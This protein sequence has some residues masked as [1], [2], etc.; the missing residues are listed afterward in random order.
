MIMN[1]QNKSREDLFN[2]LQEVRQELDRLKTRFD[3]TIS[4]SE[5]NFGK[6]VISMLETLSIING[7]GD[8]IFVN[9]HAAENLS[10]GQPEDVIGRNIGDFVPPEQARELIETYRSVLATKQHVREER[11]ITL[12][13]RER[14]FSNKL[15]FI[16]WGTEGQPAVLSI[17]LDITD[18]RN[19]EHDLRLSEER[20]RLLSSVT[21]EGILIHRNGVARDLNQSLAKMLGYEIEELLNIDFFELVHPD[22][23]A[24]ARENIIKEYAFPYEIR[25]FRKS[26][27]LIDIEVESKNFQYK[28]E[29]W[30]VSA[31]RDITARKQSN[32]EIMEAR[33]KALASEMK[34]KNYIQSSP[35]SVFITDHEGRFTFVNNSACSLVGYSEQELLQISISDLLQKDADKI[36]PGK[37][38]KKLMQTESVRNVEA[39]FI[40]KNNHI[41]D[42][43]FD[44]KKLSENEYI[45]F[46]KDISERKSAE[47]ALKNR[48]NLLNKVFDLLPIGLW[49]ADEKGKLIRGNPAGV[50]IWGAEPTVAIEEYGIFKARRLPSGEQIGPDDWALAHTIRRGVTIVDEMLEIEAFDGQKKI[51]LN[52]TAPVLDDQ[53]MIKGA[54]VVN[55]D[56]TEKQRSE[57][58]L[59]YAK[60]K[61]EES[62]RLKSAFLANMSHEI[63]TPMNGILGFADLL[64]EPDLSGPEQ[65]KYISIIEKSGQRM[66]NII[67]DII[68]I[69]KIESGLMDLNITESNINE[70]I[71]YIY[72]FFKPE[73]E[74]K[75]LEF[76][77]RND[78]PDQEAI[79][80]T[81]REK[82]FAILTNLVKNA[83]KYTT[84]GAIELGYTIAETLHATS[85]QGALPRIQVYVK[86]TGMGIPLERQ[87]AI[88]ERFIQA[89]IADKMA[90]QGAG[91]GLSISKAYVEMLGGTIWVDSHEGSGSTFYFTLPYNPQKA[92]ETV[93]PKE[94]S[95]GKNESSRNLKILIAE[96]NQE[97]E[98]LIDNYV[99][100]QSREIL[101]AR[102]GRE[103]VQACRA[104]P[105]IDLILMDIRMP[106]MGGDEAVK[107]IR[108]FNKEVVIIAQ[109]AY[110]LS[111]DKERSLD[112]GCNE[113]ISKPFRKEE[114]LE[115]I[116]QYFGQ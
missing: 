11:R 36:E 79:I 32:K 63:R 38:V 56:I 90:Y 41:I 15:Q 65:Q 72:A 7:D 88:F 8:F 4:E 50:K 107:Q 22:D 48:E 16:Q 105:D 44:A 57:M 111:G 27:E 98:M 25:M 67:N 54:I 30:R 62:D 80:R 91:L 6:V 28:E 2:E 19:A 108:E 89:D 95:Q 70:Q 86:D 61:A 21:M 109:T 33:E 37:G 110:A 24:R 116:G 29:Q 20:N 112:S 1:D 96:D 9:T 83:I 75:G 46:V 113:Y 31:L 39:K 13:G 34:F 35:T 42:V 101:K 82:V 14:W 115:L 43:V 49:F 51:I 45:A 102:N 76:T 55:Q 23:H 58:D 47:E 5:S 85:L 103:A 66:L 53:G 71:A 59:M 104:H 106:V 73:A 69:S 81:D 10:G 93:D 52:Y 74:S 60:E 17:S 92:P 40:G 68:D 84:S 77:F 26:G 12:R 3:K 114:L 100:M 94:A 18:F 78:L 97:S 87:E 64:K 99:R